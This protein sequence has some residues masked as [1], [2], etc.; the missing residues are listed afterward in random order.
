MEA[1]DLGNLEC[2]LC[3]KRPSIIF[4][5]PNSARWLR[6]AHPA[7]LFVLFSSYTRGDSLSLVFF[8]TQHRNPFN[9]INHRCAFR[10]PYNPPGTYN[11]HPPPSTSD[12]FLFGFPVFF[13][14]VPRFKDIHLPSSCG[15]REP[16]TTR[17]TCPVSQTPCTGA[18]TT[19]SPASPYPSSERVSI[20]ADREE[21]NEPEQ[22]QATSES[23]GE[24][25]GSD[26]K[27]GPDD[28]SSE[29]KEDDPEEVRFS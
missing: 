10:L 9:T 24:D 29:E 22:E 5:I 15:G 17:T 26:R 18:H 7:Y 11:V 12:V 4:L 28:D 13:T 6:M 1:L 16:S 2:R 27:K 8:F 21:N 23:Q 25:I 20:M 14:I 19:P 3:A